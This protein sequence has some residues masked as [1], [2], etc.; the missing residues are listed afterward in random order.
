LGH[1][2]HNLPCPGSTSRSRLRPRVCLRQ[3]CGQLYQP[4]RWNQRYCQDPECLRLV[5]R[6]QA[7]KR[8]QQRRA[9][10]DVRQAH[11]AAERQ[12][13]ARR[14]EVSRQV[15]KP[16]SPSAAEDGLPDRAWSRSKKYSAPFC[17]RPGCYEAVRPSC[18]CRA[19]YCG[20]D[21]RQALRRVRDRERKWL[22]RNAQQQAGVPR[23]TQ[24][25]GP[26]VPWAR[27]PTATAV[28]DGLPTE[29]RPAG[30][31]L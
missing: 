5:R 25:V 29:N 27:A 16:V 14:R 20:D 8:Q 3:G 31:Q 21:C 28:R 13:R 15:G 12:R 9:C 26:V 18:R 10:P 11:A 24:Q 6:W 30:R 2:Q 17:D 19:R 22:S 4:S 1:L 23:C 7:A